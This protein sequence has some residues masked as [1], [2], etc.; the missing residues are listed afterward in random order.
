MEPLV[1]ARI[2][3]VYNERSTCT[4]IKLEVFQYMCA[5]LRFL[6]GQRVVHLRYVARRQKERLPE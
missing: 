2:A 4:T 5:Y 6:P 3:A 1:T